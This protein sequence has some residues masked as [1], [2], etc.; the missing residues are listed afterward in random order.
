MTNKEI[1]A[2]WSKIRK[3]E[4]VYVYYFNDDVAIKFQKEESRV[5][6]Y[7]RHSR[8]SKP[9]R[10]AFDDDYMQKAW[11]EGDLITKESYDEYKIDK[12]LSGVVD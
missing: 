1:A 8:R 9:H 10:V 3:G 6:A 4:P 7:V 12:S 2:S 11:Y 5:W